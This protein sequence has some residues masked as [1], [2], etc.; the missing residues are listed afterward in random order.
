MRLLLIE[1]EMELADALAATLARQG[2][3]IDHTVLLGDAL[4]LIRQNDYDAILLDRRLPDGEGLTFIPNIRRM[5]RD[6]PIIVLTARN[7]PLERVEGL[8]IGA[9]DYLG[10]P[11]LTEEL[12]A[13]LRAVLRRPVTIVEQQITAGRMIID[14]LHL[15]VSVDSALLDIP[16][17]E[18]LVL[19]ALAKRKDKTV[20]RPT[21]EAAVYNYEEEI[22][23]NALDAHISRLRKR[24]SDAAAGVTIHNIRGVGYLLREDG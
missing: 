13:R 3:V 18:L 5:G 8:N 9:D 15:T 6:T 4:E 1:D 23:S 14:P 22:Q 7:E 11:F 20:G 2:I 24:L 19:V 17:R 10:K 12:L 21:L 16:R